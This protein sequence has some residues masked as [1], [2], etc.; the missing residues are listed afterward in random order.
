MRFYLFHPKFW[1]F[2]WWHEFT[3]PWVPGAFHFGLRP[4]TCRAVADEAPRRTRKKTSGTQGKFTQASSRNSDTVGTE[5][6][7]IQSFATKTFRYIEV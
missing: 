4:K 7:K 3:L 6:G 1:V 2:T 5:T